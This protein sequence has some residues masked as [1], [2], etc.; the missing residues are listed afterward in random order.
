V[1][2]AFED[3]PEVVKVVQ[4]FALVRVKT[5]GDVVGVRAVVLWSYD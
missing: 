5:E 3:S 4:P 2:E 1:P